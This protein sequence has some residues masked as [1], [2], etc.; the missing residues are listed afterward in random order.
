MPTQ[1]I[2]PR[3]F[4]TSKLNDLL[5]KEAKIILDTKTYDK[6]N[7]P[8]I[9]SKKG[10]SYIINNEE[11]TKIASDIE[12]G[13]YNKTIEFAQQK[14]L[15]RSWENKIFIDIYKNNII[16]V[17]SNINSESYIEN[18]R[19]FNRLISGEFSGYELASMNPQQS[20]PERW[21]VLLDEKSKRDRYLYEINKE[22][23]TDQYEC[24]RCHKRQCTYYQL[25]TRSADE[26][27][28]TF[29]TCLNCGKRWRF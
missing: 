26:P 15:P 4:S 22:M 2:D 6:K 16:S 20:F 1:A 19:L 7:I 23:A 10:R 11:I 17:Y 14:N 8:S 21:K 5:E 28:T 13:V 12:K 25:Q 27:M 24:G 18:D 29:V 3:E 9:F